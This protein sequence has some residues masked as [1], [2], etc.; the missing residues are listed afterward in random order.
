MRKKIESKE[1]NGKE[2]KPL[3]E[4]KGE[5]NMNTIEGVYNKM[6]RRISY[7]KDRDTTSK[8]LDYQD[9]LQTVM[10]DIWGKQIDNPSHYIRRA[11][12][13]TMRDNRREISLENFGETLEVKY[14]TDENGVVKE[15]KYMA[16]ALIVNAQGE[17]VEVLQAINGILSPVEKEVFNYYTQGFTCKEIAEKIDSNEKAIQRQVKRIYDKIDKL[18]ISYFYNSRYATFQGK[19]GKDG[20]PKYNMEKKYNEKTGEYVENGEVVKP[21]EVVNRRFLCLDQSKVKKQL[22]PDNYQ[23]DMVVNRKEAI[24]EIADAIDPKKYSKVFLNSQYMNST[25]PAYSYNPVE[26]YANNKEAMQLYTNRKQYA[27]MVR[28]NS[29][30]VKENRSNPIFTSTK[31]MDTTGRFRNI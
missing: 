10:T 8:L 9:A 4:V 19:Q 23:G 15:E 2:V 16:P 21:N 18:K 27:E 22:L 5:K 24:V 14:S 31:H 6:V 13:F 20:G 25:L 28:S 29:T 3:K 7:L 30:V 1:V 12:S 11:V 17:I 26:P